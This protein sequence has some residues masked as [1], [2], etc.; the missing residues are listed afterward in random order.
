MDLRLKIPKVTFE[1]TFQS[2]SVI[3]GTIPLTFEIVFGD[4][5]CD[6]FPVHDFR[7]VL[8]GGSVLP[9]R[10]APQRLSQRTVDRLR[11]GSTSHRVKYFGLSVGGRPGVAAVRNRWAAIQPGSARTL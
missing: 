11:T 8:V 7:G 10:A 4:M 3:S 2:C 5:W 6:R 1:V 9:D